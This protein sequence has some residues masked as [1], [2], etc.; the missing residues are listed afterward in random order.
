VLAQ[1]QSKDR[2]DPFTHFYLKEA[3]DKEMIKN[4]IEDEK[5]LQ[6][7]TEYETKDPKVLAEGEKRREALQD[8]IDSLLLE[9]EN[10]NHDLLQLSNAGV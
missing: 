3:R 10:Q 9:E 4:W 2:E 7:E 1:Y 5:Q 8:K 6:K